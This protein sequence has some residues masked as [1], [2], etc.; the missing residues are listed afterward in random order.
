MGKPFGYRETKQERDSTFQKEGR[1]VSES[2]QELLGGFD[3]KFKR[4]KSLLGR[5]NRSSRENKS[6]DIT[7]TAISQT[8]YDKLLRFNVLS[9]DASDIEG[10]GV[11]TSTFNKF[12]DTGVVSREGEELSVMDQGGFDKLMESISG[13]RAQIE[14]QTMA[15]G[16]NRQAFSLLSGNFS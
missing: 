11:T 6:E 4:K 14:G 13:R 5:R 1:A 8:D 3:F 2:Q 10:I 9:G 15:P 7:R 16:L 12:S